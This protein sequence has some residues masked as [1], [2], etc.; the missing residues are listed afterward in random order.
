MFDD[1]FAELIYYRAR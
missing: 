1:S